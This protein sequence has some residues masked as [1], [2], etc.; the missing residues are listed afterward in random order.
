MPQSTTVYVGT[1]THRGSEGIY[2]FRMDPETC[3]LTP[4][5]HIGGIQNPSF[6]S[7]DPKRRCLY[8]VQETVDTGAVAAFAIAPDTG[9]LTYLNQQPT[10][11][12][13]P[14]HVTIDQTGRFVLAANY[15][16]G[17]VCMMPVRD[18]G[19]LD[20]ASCVVQH[21]GSSVNPERQT[22]PHAHSVTIDPTN[23]YAFACDLGI[24]KIMAYRL[25]F[26]RGKLQPA[27][28]PFV[29][30]APGAGPRHFAFHPSGRYAYVINEMGN[31]V[32]AYAYDGRGKLTELQ[33]V[34][35][36]P[37]DYAG[38]STCADIHLAPSGR[39]VYG[40]NRGHDSLAIYAVDEG[41][42]RLTFM[43]HQPTGGRNPRNFA[44]DPTGRYV[45]AANQDTDA[46]VVFRVDPDTGAI[47]PTGQVTS[48]PCPVCVQVVP[49][50]SAAAP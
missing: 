6:L 10:H 30:T 23:G 24:D 15:G 21:E 28:P 45:L 41:T 4:D 38:K 37:A 5:S 17:N 2:V 42:G 1:Y 3:D 16:S 20:P 34:P 48:V 13:A 40:S 26:E 33:T 31:T 44:I 22:G 19:S 39:H 43:G 50:L 14:C 29:A 11:G 25:D 8:A 49:G 9:R 12:A 47:E 35:T 32:V 27:D 36:L 18:D 7:V 46:I